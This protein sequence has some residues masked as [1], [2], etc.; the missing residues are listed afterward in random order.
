MQTFKNFFSSLSSPSIDHS[1]D[2]LPLEEIK[3]VEMSKVQDEKIDSG[4]LEAG[5]ESANHSLHAQV[6]PDHG[7]KRNPFRSTFTQATILG[8]CSFLAPGLWGASELFR[9]IDVSSG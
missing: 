2:L 7:R 8:T 9:V 6:T 4:S 1:Y 3:T 5:S